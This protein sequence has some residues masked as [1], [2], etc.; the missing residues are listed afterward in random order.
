[1]YRD[2]IAAGRTLAEEL[3][4]FAGD[5]DAVV[6]GIPRGGVVIGG[7][8]ARRLDL[9]LDV[10]VASKIGAPHNPEYAVG[11]VDAS[12]HITPNLEAGYDM[13]EL[14]HLAR[15][16][17]DKV[18]RRI[19]LYRGGAQPIDLDGATAIVVDDGI[20]TGLT[21]IAAVRYVRAQGAL[22]VVL[23]VPVIASS[24]ISALTPHTDRIVAP[25]RPSHFYAVGQFYRHFAQVSDDEVLE[26]LAEFGYGG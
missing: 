9:P 3:V 19:E 14:E 6:L 7:E 12:G 24:A 4:G 15:P 17:R 23:A 22:R 10:V 16:V 5:E 21:A 26:V 8:I 1:M 25:E 20:A 2:R 13:A 18:R 11:A